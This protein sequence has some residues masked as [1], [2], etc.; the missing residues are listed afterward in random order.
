MDAVQSHLAAVRRLGEGGR[1]YEDYVQV[2]AA[3][4]D[5]LVVPAKCTAHA[6]QDSGQAPGL[7]VAATAGSFP[8]FDGSRMGTGAMLLVQAQ[9]LARAGMPEAAMQIVDQDMAWIERTGARGTEVE[10]WRVRGELLL[11]QTGATHLAAV[12]EAESCFARALEIAR[13]RETRWVELRAAV[14]LARLWEAQGRRDDAR[15]LLAGIYDWFTEG[16]DT[17]D[18]VEAKALLERLE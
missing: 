14:S 8:K 5:A 10:V 15:E 6:A 12:A 13:A 4:Q 9:I 17:V 3:Q 18:L 2:L 7:G 1:F 11:G 16:F